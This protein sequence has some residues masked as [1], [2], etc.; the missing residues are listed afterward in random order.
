MNECITNSDLIA[1]FNIF[2]ADLV[3]LSKS[4]GI[5]SLLIG[6]IA[7]IALYLMVKT[8]FDWRYDR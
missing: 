3:R 1:A 2:A 6:F 8:F 5:N 7:G 4:F